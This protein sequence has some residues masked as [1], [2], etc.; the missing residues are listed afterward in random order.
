M[1]KGIIFKKPENAKELAN[2]EVLIQGYGR[3][4]LDTLK[5]KITKDHID[6]AKYLKADNFDSYQYAMNSIAEFV[7]AVL[8]VES[9]LDTPR[10][11]RMKRR[12]GEEPVNNV[13]GGQIAGLGVGPQGEP[14]LTRAQQRRYKRRNQK[15][16]RNFI[17]TITRP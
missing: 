11:K 6:A 5:K 2:P 1:A 8:D 4:N 17:N 12:L 15:D 7:Q 10:Y 9:E 14:G 13:G 3:M 16:L